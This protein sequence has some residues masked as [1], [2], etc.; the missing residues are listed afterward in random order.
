[1]ICAILRP[2]ARHRDRGLAR[3]RRYRWEDRGVVG[4]GVMVGGH[5]QGVLEPTGCCGYDTVATGYVKGTY[6]TQK[7]LLALLGAFAIMASA[8]GGSSAT[9]A[10]ASQAPGES[11]AASGESP[12]ASADL[13]ADQVLR[14]PLIQDP[15][16]LDPNLAQD[17]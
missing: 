3:A 9:Q 8:C 2:A 6:M 4:Q 15:A 16:T 17:S 7:R 1:M 10:P 14:W 12:A 13:A 5:D 11:P